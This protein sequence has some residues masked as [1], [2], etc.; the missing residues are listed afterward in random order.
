[1]ALTHW[2]SRE[3]LEPVFV[4]S[5]DLRMQSFVEWRGEVP[6]TAKRLEDFDAR[7]HVATWI[8]H[9]IGKGIGGAYVIGY[10]A[11]ARWWSYFF[12]RAQAC[13]PD[14][15]QVWSVEAYNHEGKSWLGRFYYSP[16][17]SRWRHVQVLDAGEP[18]GRN[19]TV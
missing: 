2:R 14:G 8:R 9:N 6:L 18:Y 4:D 11:D 16:D 19:E 3:P 1:L 12:E 5:I 10:A 15:A 17:L 7:K 13:A